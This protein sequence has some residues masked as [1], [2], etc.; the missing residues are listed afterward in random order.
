MGNLHQFTLMLFLS[1]LLFLVITH[2]KITNDVKFRGKRILMIFTIV[3]ILLIQEIELC[4]L[5]PALS[6]S[7]LSTCKLGN[8]A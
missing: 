2:Q 3:A 1:L 6:S 8:S 4:E 5:G 7:P